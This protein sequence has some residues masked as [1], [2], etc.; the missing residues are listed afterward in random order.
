LYTN[1]DGRDISNFEIS[2]GNAFSSSIRDLD[3][4]SD[5]ER[6]W[7]EEKLG[8]YLP[9]PRDFWKKDENIKIRVRED[10]PNINTVLKRDD[11]EPIHL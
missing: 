9:P 4:L 11:L 2:C 3:Y 8:I 1:L 5:S 7:G 10:I 6:R